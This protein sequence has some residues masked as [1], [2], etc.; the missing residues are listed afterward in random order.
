MVGVD[1]FYIYDDDSVDGLKNIL[2]PYIADGVVTYYPQSCFEPIKFGKGKIKFGE[3]RQLRSYNDA[4]SRFRDETKWMAFI[5]TDEFMVPLKHKTI[6][7]FLKNYEDCTN[8]TVNWVYYGSSGHERREDGWVIERFK[9]HQN[10]V[11]SEHKSI[12]NPRAVI[13]PS[14]H[15][16][17]TFGGS[18]NEKKQ[19]AGIS[20]SWPASIASA[21]YIRI[22]HY[23]VRSRE[24]Y[25][26]KV[27]R[28]GGKNTHIG[29]NFFK[30][31][32][33]NEVYDD[34]MDQ[35]VERLNRKFPRPTVERKSRD[36]I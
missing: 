32:D 25:E 13:Y 15:K 17:C 28:H 33:R 1:H 4:V 12:I 11:A 3:N 2:A 14:T 22:N 10:G 36:Q 7:E 19:K 21:E 30:E 31:Y 9:W 26:Q 6:P 20:N 23:C 18:V 24:E 27:M 35:Y 16:S 8:I 29:E 34:I 5:D